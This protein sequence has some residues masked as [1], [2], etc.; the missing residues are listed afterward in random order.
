MF[1]PKSLLVPTD[2]SEYSDQAFR[3]ALDIARLHN[4]SI[5]LQHVIDG[6][7][8]QSMADYCFDIKVVE[9]V[10]NES[11]I[12]S[13]EKLKEL[14]KRFPEA[15]EVKII[16]DVRRGVPYEEILK[17]QQEQEI[18]LIVISSHGRTGLKKLL[19]G[20]V[21]EKVIR[22]AGCSVLLVKS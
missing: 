18:D 4:S 16:T 12:A 1:S 8:Q 20:S 22:G 2:F 13:H 10:V 17:N 11:I 7:I 15:K 14:I 21:T 6:S 3:K 19:I 5:I 9:R